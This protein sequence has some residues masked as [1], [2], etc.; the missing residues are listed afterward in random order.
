M[1]KRILSLIAVL[2]LLLTVF[3]ACGKDPVT[4]DPTSTPDVSNSTSDTSDIS[5]VSDTSDV[6][7]TPSGDENPDNTT[8]TKKQNTTT[9]TMTTRIRFMTVFQIS[10]VISRADEN[11]PMPAEL[12]RIS[13][14]S[15]FLSIS[16]N[17]ASM[18]TFQ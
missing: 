15:I 4:S 18:S 11:A 14:R 1:T 17:S 13:S 6:S 12:T 10:S 2:C 3:A 16:T 9:T 8:T 7:A 5:D